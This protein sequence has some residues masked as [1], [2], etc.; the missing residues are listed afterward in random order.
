LPQAEALAAEL[1]MSMAMGVTR[2][3]GCVPYGNAVFTRFRPRLP[4]VDPS[5]HPASRAGAS[6]STPSWAVYSTSS[7]HF[8]LKTASAPTRRRSF[9]SRSST[10]ISPVLACNR[11]SQRVVRRRAAR[12]ELHGPRTAARIRRRSPCSPRPH[13]LDRAIHA[14]GFHVHRSRLAR[15]A[16][17]HCPWSRARPGHAA[18]EPRDRGCPG[19][20]QS[21]RFSGA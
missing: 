5:R 3:Y 11:R 13:L 7:M 9:A 19:G 2:H 12:R 20:S 17:D 6:G 8:G 16:S 15:V 4:P 1:G 10:T 18:R 14:E 21:R